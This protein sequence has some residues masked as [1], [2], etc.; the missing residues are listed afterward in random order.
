MGVGVGE[1]CPGSEKIFNSR[2]MSV[3]RRN[4]PNVKIK[5]TVP[6][7]KIQKQQHPESFLGCGGE[8]SISQA[9]ECKEMQTERQSQRAQ[10]EPDTTRQETEFDHLWKLQ[11]GFQPGR[12]GYGSRHNEIKIIA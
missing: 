8:G 12:R 4:R 5:D 11:A 10:G 1:G 3:F 2:A 6:Y 7:A 9:D